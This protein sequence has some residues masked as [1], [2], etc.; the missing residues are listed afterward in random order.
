MSKSAIS[1]PRRSSRRAPT[2][3]DI[4]RRAGVSTATVSR[5]LATP[6][7]VTETTRSKVMAV[8]EESGYTPNATARSLRARSTKIVLAL[9]PGMSNTFFTP[10]LNAVEDTLSAAGYGMIIGDTRNSVAKETLYAR[11]IRAGQVDGVILFT[12]HLPRDE[13]ARMADGPA[14]ITLVCNEIPGETSYSIFDVANRQAARAATDYLIAAGHR[15]IAHIGGPVG[16]IE[17]WER[18]R[19]FAEALSAA[20]LSFDENLIWG[21]G[22][23]YESGL[24][25]AASYLALDDPP[26]AVFAGADHAAIGFIRTLREAGIGVPDDVSVIGFDDIDY[27]SVVDPPLTTMR[28]PRAELGRLAAEDLLARMVRGAP[29][30]PPARL[31][32]ACDL[33]ERLSVRPPTGAEGATRAGAQRT[34][35]SR[36]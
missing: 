32:L 34:R 15:R 2:I 33:S 14:P 30:I 7:R 4:A 6:E 23:R 29:K 35:R 1:D 17:A 31:R 9:V 20:G 25:A 3:L 12:G 27:C 18:K 10:I 21:H 5:A 13:E 26:T 24:D 8:I 28:Q 19:G 16:N 36:P 22:F 11:L